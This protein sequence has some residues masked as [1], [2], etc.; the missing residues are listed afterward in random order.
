MY[1]RGV[2]FPRWLWVVPAVFTGC[3]CSNKLGGDL[4][5]NGQPFGASSC[6]NGARY[7]FAGVEVSGKDGWK[8]RFVQTPTGSANVVVFKP[9]IATGVELG[10]CGTIRVEMQNSTV[11]DVKNVQG[12][13][14]VSCASDGLT[15]AGKLTFGNCH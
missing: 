15:V 12:S 7:G 1:D 11:N 8:L 6:R 2:R 9:G 3:F 10:E 14:E 5:L 4:Q 13:A